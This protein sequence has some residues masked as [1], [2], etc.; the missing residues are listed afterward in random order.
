MPKLSDT[1]TEGTLVKW[2]IG[3]GDKVGIGDVI[4]EVETDKATMEVE[5]FDEGVVHELF[6]DEGAKV[7]IGGRMALLLDEGED[8]PENLDEVEGAG[9]DAPAG[10]G[11]GDADGGDS[12]GAE[13]KKKDGDKPRRSRSR[14]SRSGGSAGGGRV[15]ARTGSGRIKASPLAR[16]VADE[17]GVDLEQVEGTGPGG[18]IVRADVEDA[19]DSAQ[20]GGAAPAAGSPVPVIR[21]QAGPDD[22]R[23]ALSGMRAVIAERLLASKTQIPHFYLNIEIDAGA[24]MAFRKQV[25]ANAEAQP[26]GQGNKYTLNDFILRAVVQACKEVPAVNAAFDGDAVVRFAAVHLA[27][28]V[29]LDEGL[30]TPVIRDAHDKTLL[31]ISRAVKDL[32]TRARGKKLKPDEM[33][34]GTITVS[35]LGA[36]GID[37]FDAIINP[38]QAAILSIGA[39]KARPV[40]NE[41][42]E[43]AVG[44]RMW[45]GM[46][47]DHRVIDGAIGASYLS[48]LQRYLENPALMLI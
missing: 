23:V 45:I 33:Q 47:C 27:V 42:G 12:G 34:G 36:Y 16:R 44:Q 48:A 7:V 35:N 43:L 14:R 39:I 21:P 38:P 19:A 22:E 3:K 37:N 1:M 24:L 11:E 26:E 29:A 25:N 32:A 9:G 4:A 18:R 30:V 2:T 40:V 6:V 20:T 17:L 10:D 5:A 13:D 15:A 41:K 8:P 46:S 28:A 31:D